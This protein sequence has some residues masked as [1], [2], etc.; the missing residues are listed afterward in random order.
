MPDYQQAKIYKIYS[1][2]NPDEIYIGSTTNERLSERMSKHR[3]TFINKDKYTHHYQTKA[4]IIFEKYGIENCIIELIENYPCISKDE[5]NAREGYYIRTLKCVNRNIPDRTKEEYRKDNK[6]KLNQLTKTWCE[7]N[8]ERSKEIKKNWQLRNPEKV[9]E[10]SKIYND[11]KNKLK[12]TCETCN[13]E[14]RNTSKYYHLT[15]KKHLD[16]TIL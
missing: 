2:L 7:K 14:M 10:K 11:I 4:F 16:N 8:K 6:E 15:T 1:H 5:L 3:N 13:V 9:K 12:W